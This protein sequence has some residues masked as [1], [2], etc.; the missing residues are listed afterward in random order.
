[1]NDTS[2]Q[3]QYHR[4]IGVQWKYKRCKSLLC[5]F[6]WIWLGINW[7]SGTLVIHFPFSA[8]LG[9]WFGSREMTGYINCIQW[10]Y[11]GLKPVGSLLHDGALHKNRHVCQVIL[12]TRKSFH[13][14]M[15]GNLNPHNLKHFCFCTTSIRVSYY[16]HTEEIKYQSQLLGI[17]HKYYG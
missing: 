9:N 14:L 2:C 7:A 16:N 11:L 6:K 13:V 17:N 10:K 1:M 15:R 4:L 3:L 12:I 5:R 8:H